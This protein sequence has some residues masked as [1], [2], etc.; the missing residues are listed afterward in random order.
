[1]GRGRRRRSRSARGGR[2]PCSSTAS[3][4]S[5]RAVAWSRPE[6]AGSRRWRC[7]S[8]PPEILGG[9]RATPWG[10]VAAQ[11]TAPLGHEIPAL[12]PPREPVDKPE[13]RLEIE[14]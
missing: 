8:K 2:S 11:K 10:G 9:T 7:S 12:L 6:I 5:G 3:E 14:Y 13:V 1:A 4:S